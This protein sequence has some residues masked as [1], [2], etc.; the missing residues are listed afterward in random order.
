M[1]GKSVS[2]VAT[3]RFVVATIAA[4]VLGVLLSARLD[5]WFR[6][7]TP[8]TFAI[9]IFV[10]VALLLELAEHRLAV[11]ATGSI[12]FI[13]FIASALVFGPTWGSVVTAVSFTGAHLLNR[14][15]L[16]KVG[17]NV[18][19]YVLAI[20]LSSVTYMAL[21]GAIPPVSLDHSV[22]PFA[23]MVVVFFSVNSLA[24]SNVVALS[25]ERSLLEVWRRNTWHLAAY[26]L[27]ASTIALAIAFLYGR[28]GVF[29][30]AGV[31]APILFLRHIYMVNLQLQ[32]A[33]RE[34]L[35]VMVKSI[36][37]RDPYTSGH[38]QRVAEFARLIARELG[39]GLGETDKIAT[40]AL[41]HDVGKI[42]E[43]FAPL[44]RKPSRLTADEFRT[45]RS[46]PLKSAELVA[47]VSG[48][49]GYIETA[50]RHH[51][52]SL[53]GSGYPDGLKGE[54]IPI[55][56]RVI[57]VADTVDAMTSHRPYRDALLYDEVVA[58]TERCSGTQFDPSVV[59]AFRSCVAIRKLLDASRGERGPD[60]LLVPEKAVR[61][62]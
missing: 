61:L 52:E 17:F 9:M 42:Y 6:V 27:F 57:M 20:L 37:A 16:L 47:T 24:V 54:D 5:P 58:E 35:D 41:L 14:R 23:V 39:L 12:A 10:V 26:D 3:R 2:N 33:N 44:L 4:A 31:V 40:A 38:S 51:H 30:V 56:A 8:S 29:A 50:V 36:E 55:G 21:G 59:A 19:Q 49:R 43:E 1:S 62:A 22:G 32:A 60:P 11:S 45:M 34:M 13:I 28:Y 7:Q 48:L 15:P 46:H 18:S 53:D 25:E